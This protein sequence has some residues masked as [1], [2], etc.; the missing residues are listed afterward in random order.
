MKFEYDHN[1]IVKGTVITVN[2]LAAFQA[3]YHPVYLSKTPSSHKE[4]L[5][6]YQGYIIGA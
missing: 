5:Y 2:F 6:Q 1:E 3:K 4:V